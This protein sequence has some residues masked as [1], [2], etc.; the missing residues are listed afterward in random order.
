MFS[1]LN[2]LGGLIIWPDQD[3]L[4]VVVS[5]VWLVSGVIW[6]VYITCSFS[7]GTVLLS[8][9]F[10]FLGVWY[11]T[12]LDVKFRLD[13]WE[14]LGGNILGLIIILDGSSLRCCRFLHRD[15][16]DGVCTMYDLGSVH[17]WVTT[18]GDHLLVSLSSTLMCCSTC[19]LGRSLVCWS[20]W[21]FWSVCLWYSHTV[22]CTFY[23]N[24]S[25]FCWTV[26]QLVMGLHGLWELPE[27]ITTLCLCHDHLR[28]L[29]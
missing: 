19:R 1:S 4:W 18:A 27:C 3:A 15:F 6:G 11:V 17:L 24:I 28:Q 22:V 21:N 9:I 5:V 13:S 2:L 16:P 7:V 14:I 29:S 20:W 12:L 26:I 25:V 10:C 23:W 8:F